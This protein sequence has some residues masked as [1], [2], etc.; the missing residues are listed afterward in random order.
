MDATVRSQLRDTLFKGCTRPAMLMGVPLVP[1]V[2]ACGLCMLVAA[3]GVFMSPWFIL[4]A[5]M[6]AVVLIGLMRQVTRGDDQRLRQW[7]LRLQLRLL[8]TAARRVWGVASYSAVR[9][10]R[11]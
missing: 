9:Y 6:L 8:H 7:Q 2:L 1:L 3:W 4:V 11:R 10:S 5:F